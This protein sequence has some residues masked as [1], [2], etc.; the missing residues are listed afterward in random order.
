M[1]HL[2]C[3]FHLYCFQ[4]HWS[5]AYHLSVWNIFTETPICCKLLPIFPWALLNNIYSVWLLSPKW[6][7]AAVQWKVYFSDY[8]EAWVPSQNLL[9]T[10]WGPQT[11]TNFL[12]MSSSFQ[13]KKYNL[14]THTSR[15]IMKMVCDDNHLKS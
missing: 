14:S 8:Q 7:R 10:I 6:E 4:H 1:D 9:L 2:I 5:Q 15:V 12:W 11:F 3:L 13:D